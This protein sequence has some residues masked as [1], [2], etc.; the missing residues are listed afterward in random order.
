MLGL[1]LKKNPNIRISGKRKVDQLQ[2][3]KAREVPT[4]RP[5]TRGSPAG[6]DDHSKDLS[7]IRVFNRWMWGIGTIQTFE[8]RCRWWRTRAEY[9]GI[10]PWPL[11]QA[12]IR[13]AAALLFKGGYRSAP[14]YLASIKR[15]H[16]QG[17]Y[18][19]PLKVQLEIKDC[20]RALRRGIGPPRRAEPFYLEKIIQFADS[21]RQGDL[22][23][24]AY[25]SVLGAWWM[26]REVELAAV[27]VSQ[28]RWAPC[29]TKDQG[30]FATILLPISKTD[31]QAL[32]KRRSH[33]CICPDPACPVRAVTTLLHD[34]TQGGEAL[35]PLLVRDY[36]GLPFSKEAVTR[37][38]QLIAGTTGHGD[39]LITGHSMRV[40]G[41][42]RMALAG[43]PV[44]LVKVYGRWASEA[45]MAYLRETVIQGDGAKVAEKVQKGLAALPAVAKEGNAAQYASNSSS[46]LT[47]PAATGGPRVPEAAVPQRFR[48][49]HPRQTYVVQE[50]KAGELLHRMG[51]PGLT[52]C[53]WPW[54]Q[55][56]GRPRGRILF[57][58]ML[59]EHC[60]FRA[61]LH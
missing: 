37:L 61:A 48:L 20:S 56:G 54:V 52:Q 9:R 51:V 10:E 42:M 26:M 13:L 30:G 27:R 57:K 44:E 14:N 58:H 11:T 28:I 41:A 24:I 36:Q 19:L 3:K 6:L 45:V 1:D 50:T 59:C 40:T 8:T 7:S 32:G 60:N 33:Q 25:A 35:D 49:A 2:Q 38:M 17:G 31:I 39:L 47:Q 29:T 22:R 23:T 21:Q 55:E 5:Y 18:D 16:I 46:T 34:A 53:A 43:L 15:K 12:K 4:R